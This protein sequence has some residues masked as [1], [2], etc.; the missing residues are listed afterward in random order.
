MVH[1][2]IFIAQYATGM[3]QYKRIVSPA[4]CT[5][6]SSILDSLGKL[7]I[8]TKIFSIA[9]TAQKGFIKGER[10]KINSFVDCIFIP[11][12]NPANRFI[13]FW[14]RLCYYY[15][16]TR[17][18]FK[19]TSAYDTLW[20]YHT[21]YIEWLFILIAK[22]KKLRL[23]FEIEEIYADVNE[24]KC[25]KWLE[26]KA[27]KN[28]DAYV[29][30]TQ[31]LNRIINKHNKP[32][33]IIE[34]TYKVEPAQVVP[35]NKDIIHVIYAGTL[36]PRKGGAMAAAAAAEYLPEGY[37]IHI[38]GFGSGNQIQ[39]IEKQIKQIQQKTKC[40]VSFDGL[41][42]G[43]EYNCFLQNC[44]IGLSTQNPNA[45]FNATSFPSKIL[46]Y[47]ANGLHVVSIR[48]PAIEE[49]AVNDLLTY[50]DKQTPQEIAKAIM[51]VDLKAPYDSRE[52]LKQLD[53]KFQE[54][55]QKL[56]NDVHNK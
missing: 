35:S 15:R 39:Y 9:K 32:S 45:A 50:Y 18:I 28:A 30:P 48:L 44:H 26:F 29:F 24:N 20:L 38:L 27:F 33:V 12:K 4:A 2:V 37:H 52:R 47:L 55:L 16:L 3:E 8:N 56:L 36:D 43:E 25:K 40:K 14:C 23:I 34:G 51:A 19:E 22:I 11:H 53:Q 5:K 42:I 17:L 21:Y 7:K 6:I 1:N 54:D 31:Q 46:S 10:M 49:S 41:K 13:K